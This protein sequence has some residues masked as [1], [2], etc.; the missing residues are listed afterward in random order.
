MDVDSMLLLFLIAQFKLGVFAFWK[1][2]KRL[3]RL[4]KKNSSIK[5]AIIGLHKKEFEEMRDALHRI[6]VNMIENENK[7]IGM[8]MVE[9]EAENIANELWLKGEGK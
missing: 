2:S 9:Q 1:L 3:D 5:R 8:E 4:E 6:N 7:S